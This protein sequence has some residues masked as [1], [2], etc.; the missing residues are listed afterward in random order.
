MRTTPAANE[1]TLLAASAPKVQAGGVARALAVCLHGEVLD[2]TPCDNRSAREL[3]GRETFQDR[4]QDLPP[5][6]V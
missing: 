2:P 4:L 5:A 3:L 1:G 6:N